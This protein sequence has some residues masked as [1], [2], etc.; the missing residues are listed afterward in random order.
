MRSAS[1]HSAGRSSSLRCNN[2]YISSWK[3]VSFFR[4][5]CV[6]GY[7]ILQSKP[8]D[9]E[10]ENANH[11]VTPG[12]WRAIAAM[13]DVEN[14]IGPNL[15]ST[16]A[17]KLLEY[18]VVQLNSWFYALAGSHD[19]SSTMIRAW[20]WIFL[21]FSYVYILLWYSVFKF[22]MTDRIMCLM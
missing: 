19:L 5:W 14:I 17:K 4:I 3:P 1:W 21:V 18:I 20:L 12:S 7:D 2:R 22:D 16:V 9:I 15:E 6:L 10:E 13:H 11:Q 8:L